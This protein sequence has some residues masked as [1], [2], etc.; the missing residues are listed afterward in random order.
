MPNE[1]RVIVVVEGG[2][3]QEVYA[4]TPLDVSVLDYDNLE[5]DDS[6]KE[7]SEELL[8]ETKKLHQVF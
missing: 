6:L 4:S 1:P 5:A 3:V 7:E 8:A 2:V